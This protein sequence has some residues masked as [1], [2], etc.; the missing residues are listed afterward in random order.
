MSQENGWR[1]APGAHAVPDVDGALL[2]V[3]PTEQVARVQLPA[4]DRVLLLAALA[5][6][7]TPAQALQAASV[8]ELLR[9]VFDGCAAEGIAGPVPVEAPV[10]VGTVTVTG[11]NPIALA[12]AD[13]LAA[14]GFD[15]VAAAEDTIAGDAGAGT[16]L[17]VACAGWL[18]DRRWQQVDAACHKDGRPWHRCHLEGTRIVMGPFSVPGGP[19][20]CDTRTRRLAAAAWP[21]ELEAVWRH[22]DAAVNL[23]PEPWPDPGVCALVA[24]LLAADVIAYRSG[25]RPPGADRQVVLDPTDLRWQ[26]HPVLPVPTG[27]MVSR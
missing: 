23:P 27:I 24:G 1:L 11:A 12:L 15:V 18:P 19:S 22:L 2:L 25:R 26:A 14:A 20:Y 6:E 5:G 9:E 7:C 17:L 10:N 8:P 16:D 21:D 13:V 4:S 3:S